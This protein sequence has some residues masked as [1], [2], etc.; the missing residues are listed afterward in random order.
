LHPLAVCAIIVVE[1]QI[2]TPKHYKTFGI[3]TLIIIIA[4]IIRLMGSWFY[5]GSYNRE[6]IVNRVD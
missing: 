2:M 1:V 5:I 3:A 6:G 4:V